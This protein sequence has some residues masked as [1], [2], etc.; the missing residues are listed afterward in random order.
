MS[1][2]VSL[3]TEPDAG[4]DAKRSLEPEG[5]LRFDR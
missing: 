5:E 3:D 4:I 1:P 2:I